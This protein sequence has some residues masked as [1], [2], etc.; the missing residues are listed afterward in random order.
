MKKLL[1]LIAFVFIFS[2]ESSEI[3]EDC[4]WICRVKVTY[5][6]PNQQPNLVSVWMEFDSLYC[7]CSDEFIQQWEQQNTWNDT[8]NKV[9]TEQKAS[10]I[11]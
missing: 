9:W 4:C 6:Y 2:C 3:S 1:L 7:N 11:K 8:I 5:H 10:C